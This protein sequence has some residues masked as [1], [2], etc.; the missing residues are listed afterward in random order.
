MGG[1][2]LDS[3]PVRCTAS[4]IV[5]SRAYPGACLPAFYFVLLRAGAARWR[6]VS[7]AIGTI[8]RNLGLHG[9]LWMIPCFCAGPVIRDRPSAR[10]EG[11]GRWRP[12]TA[13]SGL[14]CDQIAAKGLAYS[15]LAQE[16]RGGPKY[17]LLLLH[18]IGFIPSAINLGPGEKETTHEYCQGLLLPTSPTKGAMPT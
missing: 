8:P 2:V 5:F 4:R 13:T 16:G 1:I 3:F 18:L 12:I 11:G 14:S 7:S 15:R 17:L 6:Q 9:G 10:R